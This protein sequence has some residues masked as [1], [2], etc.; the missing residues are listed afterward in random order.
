MRLITG[1]HCQSLLGGALSDDDDR[2]NYIQS[3]H[4][5]NQALHEENMRVSK[6]ICRS[7]FGIVC[8]VVL[9]LIAH[10]WIFI[11]WYVRTK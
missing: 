7:A 1:C 10:V 8:V 2:W 3:L 6:R 11:D 9:A 4:E 5:D